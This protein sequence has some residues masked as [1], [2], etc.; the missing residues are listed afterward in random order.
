MPLTDHSGQLGLQ[1][2]AHL[3][4]RATFGAT[5]QKIFE[6][7]TKTAD[8]AI[9][10]L[11]RQTLPAPLPPID[12]LTGQEWMTTGPT[13]ANSKTFDLQ[14]FFKCW[15]IGQMMSPGISSTDDLNLAHAAREKLVFFLHTHFTTIREKVD[16]SRALYFQNQ[17]FRFFALDALNPDPEINFKTLTVKICVDS[18]MLRVLDGTSNVKGNPNE[19]YARELLELYSIGRGLEGDIPPPV[20][21]DYFLYTEDD[22]KAAAKVLSGWTTDDN[23][24][25]IDEL[26]LLPRGRVRGNTT[27]ASSHDNDPKQ[28]SARFNNIVI[29]GTGT[30]EE[31]ALD[32]IQQLIDMIYEQ[33]ET[34]LAAAK[35]ICWKI[36]RFYVWGPHTYDEAKPIDTD[37]ITDMA[38]IFVSNGYKLQPVIEALLKSTHFY[39]AGAGAADDNFGG[40]IKSPLDLIIGSLRF[41]DVQ[42]P[43]MYTDA[44]AF[45]EKAQRIL[46]EMS[47]QG[48]NFYDPYDVAGYEAYHQYPIYHRFWITP[49][50]LTTRYRFVRD[51]VTQVPDNPFQVNVYQYTRDNFSTVAASAL[52]L[53]RELARYLL[54]VNVN[55]DYDDANDSAA[56]PPGITSARLN[57]FKLKLLDLFSEAEWTD[58]WNND[59]SEL[60]VQ[61]QNLYNAM[62]Q[63]PEY[64][65]S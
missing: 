19:N 52:D 62:L 7:S 23:Y 33:S 29:Q 30:T 55:I 14:D 20:D 6:F 57:Y 4:R 28:F 25:T 1:G 13:G 50:N 2:A 21:G 24:L 39:Q 51:L 54:P 38:N 10:I 48:M 3:L 43:D 49:S 61:L 37:I 46:G 45:Y 53:V 64:Q 65:L 63:S 16:D 34:T 44:A 35:N 27:N 40:I 31:S 47:D 60:R 5:K 26:T 17:L 11:F 9:A 12:P 15:F 18:A 59:D 41:F 56:L 22:V 42:L 8:E 58:Y 32:E 36:Y